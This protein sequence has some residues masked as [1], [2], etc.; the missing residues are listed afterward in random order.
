MKEQEPFAALRFTADENLKD[1]LYW[2]LAPFSLNAGEEVLAPVGVHDKLQRA[3]VERTLEAPLREAPYELALMKRIAARFGDRT[4]LLGGETVLD[5]GGVRYDERHYTRLHR[6]Y[7]SERLP[8]AAESALR[9]AV[10]LSPACRDG[11]IFRAIA[12]GNV[13]LVGGEGKEIFK[14]LYSFL[15]GDGA[16]ASALADLSLGEHEISLLEQRLK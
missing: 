6:L 15:R 13:L 1:R 16:A 2:Y 14:R 8:P 10:F 9:A 7:L 5:F 12:S 3:V 4:F 11:E